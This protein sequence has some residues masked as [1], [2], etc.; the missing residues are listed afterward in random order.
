[1]QNETISYDATAME[2][3]LSK[4]KAERSEAIANMLSGAVRSLFCRSDQSGQATLDTG[5]ASLAG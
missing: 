1:M 5:R 2:A 3:A 4:A